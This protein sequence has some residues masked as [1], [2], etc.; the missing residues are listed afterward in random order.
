MLM[1]WLFL[2][3]LLLLLSFD[4][5]G[6]TLINT[7]ITGSSYV[8]VVVVFLVVVI[9][10]LGFLASRYYINHQRLP[11]PPFL[12]SLYHIKR[13]VHNIGEV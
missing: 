11:P 12:W 6:V 7:K 13:I 1:L 4:I 9:V 2:L 5:R 3:K 8:D 10:A